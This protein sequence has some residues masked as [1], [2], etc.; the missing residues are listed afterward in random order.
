VVIPD[1]SDMKRIRAGEFYATQRWHQEL[2]SLGGRYSNV[3]IIDL[4]E[5]MPADY[6][7]LF[8]SC[9]HHWNEAGHLLAANVIAE[10]L[11]SSKSQ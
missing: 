9:D 6:N 2:A 3:D 4:S 1:Q 10:R 5:H 7:R 8:L 11:R